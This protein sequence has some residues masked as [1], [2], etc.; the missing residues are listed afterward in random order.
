MNPSLHSGYEYQVG[1][2]LP[3]DAPTYVMRQADVDLYE[4]LKVGAFCYV[5][6][7]RQMGKSSLRVQTMQRLQAAGVACA[8]IDLTKIGSQNITADQWYAGIA[9]GLVNSFA[10]AEAVNLR[11]WWRERDYLSPVQRLSELLETV[12]L[13]NLSTAIVIFVDEIDSILSLNFSTDDFFALIRDC[14]NDRADKPHYQRL[15]FA[16][17][18]VATPSDLIQDKSRTPFNIGQAIHLAGFQLQEAQ[19][20]VAG[21]AAK[22]G[23][24]Q[25]LLA[26][27]LRWTGGQPFL[28]QKLCKLVHS[29]PGCIPAG[30]EVAWLQNLVIAKIVNNWEAQDEPEHLR[31]IRDRLLR[32]ESQRSRLLGLYQHLLQ[33][34]QLPI[35]NSREHMELRLSGLITERYGLLRVSNPIY[36]AIFNL[37]WVE[38]ELAGLRPYAEAFAAWIASEGQDESRLL[39]GQALQ[40]ALKWS[41]YKS[42]SDW[43]YQYLRASQEL[44]KRQVQLALETQQQANQILAE[45]QRQA[46][47]TIRKGFAGLVM[48]LLAAIGI[49]VWANTVIQEAQTETKAAQKGLELEKVSGKVLRQ[50][51]TEEIS[52]L[53]FVLKAGRD[54]QSN[55]NLQQ[56][57]KSYPTSSFMETLQM[58]LDEI[59]EQNQFLGH[60]GRIYS[61]SLSP[62]GKSIA[63]I[64]EDGTVRLWNMAGQLLR[65]FPIKINWT[66]KMTMSVSFSPN[67]KYLATAS[68]H[69]VARLWDLSGRE[70]A[71]FKGHQGQVWSVSFSPN[72]QRLVTGGADG[73][74]RIWDLTGKSVG[75]LR[76]HHQDIWAAKF[77][78]S[79]QQI[80]TVGEDGTAR[81]WNLSGRQL[82][83][84][85]GHQGGVFSLSFS[86]DG[87]RLATAG[88]DK[89]VR[90]WSL[91]GQPL[92]QWKGSRD[93]IFSVSFSPNGQT[94]ATAGADNMIKIWDLSGELLAQLKGHQGWVYSIG[95]APD[96]LHL[97]SVS[98]DKTVRLWNL[99]NLQGISRQQL[100]R[101][102]A[103][104][105]P[106]W[107]VN[108]SPDGNTIAAAGK[109][110]I[111]R[112][113]QSAG[114]Q[115]AALKGHVQ[116]VNSIKF[117]RDGQ[118]LATAGQD[119]TI[120]LWDTTGRSLA[121]VTGHQGAVYDLSFSPTENQIAST[122]ND[123]TV[124]IW[125]TSG[126]QL[127]QWNA[128]QKPI[129]SL[130]FSPDGA[131]LI[132][133]GADGMA[134]LWNVTGQP[135][136]ELAG[137]QGSV[138]NAIFS[139][140]GNRIVTVGTDST[141]RLW[142]LSGQQLNKFNTGGNTLNVSFSPDGQTIASAQQDGTVKLWLVAAGQQITSFRG[143]Q[144]LVY[145][146]SFSADGQ[147]L[148]AAGKDG[149][150]RTWRIEQLDDLLDRG[151]TWLK[152]YFALRP[153]EAMICSKSPS[154]RP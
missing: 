133:A 13:A 105:Q 131:R 126:Q 68:E 148:V 136:V 151:C 23:D 33:S 2:S 36:Q 88:A 5:L 62:D 87:Q 153:K 18:G 25:M 60:R 149:T 85:K 46:K 24:P 3:V 123:G 75:Q 11:N 63:T 50:F 82:V 150:V 99:S 77:S 31:T 92:T 57:A 146:V 104:R 110:G 84:F 29:V 100:V 45:A 8:A 152:D 4:G 69:G 154:S 86:P 109:D 103:S 107:S 15:T 56:F 118:L 102:N 132:T 61:V 47:R 34:S 116:G 94:L 1:G 101:I 143:F 66:A 96:R 80:A 37:A 134:H 19:P 38:A 113:W 141:V 122:G 48:M 44:D 120:R 145:S 67:G 144:G 130:N 138:L 26:E 121:K 27:I 91:S 89:T 20:L 93:L 78:P 6:N 59:Y 22:A 128:S 135:I 39:Q 51:K 142:N 111:A 112:L 7:S 54:W 28:T 32:N 52:T 42:L 65:Q 115:L 125:T 70:L 114:R 106:I 72:G 117:S 147:Y 81:L 17:L 95:F 64:S 83:Q 35:D 55:H 9:R 74:A 73:I 76:G 21:L 12:V 40:D 30:T 119:G 14:Y 43:D 98:W 90:I 41:A 140:D 127:V 71:Q 10:L 139:P 53:L 16:L 108:F 58:I 79:G 97:I 49:I 124:R 137:H 129:Y